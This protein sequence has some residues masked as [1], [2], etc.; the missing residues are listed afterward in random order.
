[1]TSSDTTFLG[2]LAGQTGRLDQTGALARD[3][4]SEIKRQGRPLTRLNERMDLVMYAHHIP[5]SLG[6]TAEAAKAV[7]AEYIKACDTARSTE[8]SGGTD[9]TP[10]AVANPP[11]VVRQ[12][13]RPPKP[14]RARLKTTRDNRSD[15]MKIEGEELHRDCIQG[16]GHRGVLARYHTASRNDDGGGEN[17]NK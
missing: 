1:M 12:D 3:I 8:L 5:P 14:T 16:R 7:W 10:P 4:A 9:Q 11:A 6:I 2:W 17:K 13:P 15:A